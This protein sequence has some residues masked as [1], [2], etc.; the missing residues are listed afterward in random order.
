MPGDET[1]VPKTPDEWADVFA[2]GIALDRSR[3]AEEAAKTEA[4]KGEQGKDGKK[5]DESKPKSWA[6]RL[7]G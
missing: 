3:M 4:A 7:L 6:E 5:E 2:K 1:W